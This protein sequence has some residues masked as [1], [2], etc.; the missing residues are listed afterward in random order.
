MPAR[1]GE[2]LHLQPA[3]LG[4][5]PRRVAS[6]RALDH[7]HAAALGGTQYIAQRAQTGVVDVRFTGYRGRNG[8]TGHRRASIGL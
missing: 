3:Q 7:E 2:L 4:L 6:A 8:G 1:L 5:K